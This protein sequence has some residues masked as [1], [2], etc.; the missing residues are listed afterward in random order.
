VSG[1]FYAVRKEFYPLDMPFDLADD[2]IVPLNV[3]KNKK[4]VVL[5]PNAICREETVVNDAQE[6]RK[7]YRITIQNIRGML[8]CVDML[9]IFKYG[10][11]AW[12]L[13]SHKVL[14]LLSPFILIGIFIAS[15][16]L[17]GNAFVALF[18]LGQIAFYLLGTASHFMHI[19]NPKI[20]NSVHYF[21]LSNYSILL[22][23]IRFFNGEKV[24]T[25][26]TAR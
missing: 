18:L 16:V 15:V 22:G 5:E 11:Y 2:L 23:F 20:V 4:R 13:I 25:W 14:R 3:V 24:V 9:N 21:C 1:T 26:E 6:I 8:R 17:S 7:R 12:M 19:K 10:L